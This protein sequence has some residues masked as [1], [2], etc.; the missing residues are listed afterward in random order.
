MS[1][2]TC[3]L[4]PRG[5]VFY[6]QALYRGYNACMSIVFAGT[7]DRFREL[8]APVRS[9]VF[10]FWIY[11]FTGA[12]T[13]IFTQVLLYERY[14][15]VALNVT[16]M[17]IFFTGL[18]VGFCV[19]GY[20]AS[21]FHL[22]IKQ[23]FVWSFFVM[24]AAV[25]YIWASHTSVMAYIAMFVSGIGQG[26][27]WLTIHTFEL[28]ET[29]DHERDFYSSLLS[30]GG[31][32]LGLAGPAC[33][34]LLIWLSGTVLHWGNFTLLFL[35][36]PLV[37]L[38]GFFCF[39]AIRDYRPERIEGTDLVHFLTDRKNL[40]AQPYLAAVGFEHIIGSIVM[41]LAIL[42]IVG[43]AVSVGLYNTMFAVFSTLCL[44]L[45]AQYRKPANRLQ[46]LGI[47]SVVL[48]AS[49][50]WIGYEFTLVALVVYAIIAGI[51]S[52]MFQVS[53]HVIDLQT[54]ESIGR[55]EKDFYATMIF[56]D[57]VFWFTRTIGGLAFLIMI[58]Y[59][60]PNEKETLR[61]GLYLVALGLLA[62]YG[63]AR[64]LLGT[65]KPEPL[66]P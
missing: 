45:L 21:L 41:P 2:H 26:L 59:F 6:T 20:V 31:Q 27:F 56:R 29:R 24:G 63:G 17:V 60:M 12:L 9:L 3:K 37:Y 42:S 32:I 1:L 7:M 61:I 13:S 15:S 8:R 65:T 40:A 23:G 34:T 19:Y 5:G 18:M 44:L 52:P 28:T 22:N 16:A 48:A 39:S 58:A 62:I 38:L 25:V 33:A 10:L 47:A 51:F 43:S 66:L 14:S 55:P 54:M 64:N 57:L 53:V 30:M 11:V 4:L 49:T 36:A 35:A 46:I 50:V